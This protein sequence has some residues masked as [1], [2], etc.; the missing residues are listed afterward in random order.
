MAML[1][2]Q[3][4]P[5][6]SFALVDHNPTMEVNFPPPERSITSWL[7][8]RCARRLE[9]WID[10]SEE[11]CIH[12][13]HPK[14]TIKTYHKYWKGLKEHHDFTIQRISLRLPQDRHM[15]APPLRSTEF[16]V[17]FRVAFWVARKRSRDVRFLPASAAGEPTSNMGYLAVMALQPA[18]D[19]IMTSTYRLYDLYCDNEFNGILTDLF[20]LV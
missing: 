3:R 1:N 10:S 19:I 7:Q 16:R 14:F 8:F 9:N 6:A 15:A 12:Q 18:I 2:N 4:V 17:A 13:E 5:L 11:H 20:F